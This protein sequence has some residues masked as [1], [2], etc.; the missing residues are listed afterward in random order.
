MERV[1][2]NAMILKIISGGQTGADQAALDA[3][4]ITGTP[5][6]GWVP[7]GRLTERGPLSEKYAMDELIGGGYSDR[8]EKNVLE[9]DGTIIISHGKLTGG[10]EFTMSMAR[11]HNRPCLHIDL[12][13]QRV[14]EG[15][16]S[17]LSWLRK[18][19]T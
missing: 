2:N 11:K 18:N 10:S 16:E 13:S 15:V 7:E 5:Y 9:S 19:I 17:I 1:N 6:G 3:A 12:N 14:S 4:I 8:T